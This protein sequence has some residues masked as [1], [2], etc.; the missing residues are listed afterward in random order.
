LFDD[1]SLADIEEPI[2][3]FTVKVS[4]KFVIESFIDKL[5]IELDK[6]KDAASEPLSPVV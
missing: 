1:C 6:A 3:L 4:S 5:L 2:S